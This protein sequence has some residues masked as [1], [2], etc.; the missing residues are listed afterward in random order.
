[1]GLFGFLGSV[2]SASVKV[3]A[4]PLAVVSDVVNVAIGNEADSTKKVINSIGDDVTDSLDEI[5]D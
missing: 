3:V 5:I 1:M 2:A 4:T